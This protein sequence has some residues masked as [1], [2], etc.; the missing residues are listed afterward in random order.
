MIKVDQIGAACHT[1]RKNCFFTSLSTNTQTHQ[2]IVDTA[3]SYDIFDTLYHTIQ[4]RKKESPDASYV[5]KLFAKGDNAFL[6]K[7]VEEA[8]EFCFAVKDN[9]DK[10][11]IYEA[12]DLVF[13]LLVALASRNI[14]IDKIR[15]ELQRREGV[16]G[17]VEKNSRKEK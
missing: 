9:D 13:H 12:S 6:K 8:G 16:S 15:Q 14:S 1:G 2:P 17:I 4:E 11:I 3:S 5:A 7:V 10:E